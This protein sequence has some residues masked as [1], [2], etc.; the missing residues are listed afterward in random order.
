MSISVV[1]RF[2]VFFPLRFSL[3][4]KLIVKITSVQVI[5]MKDPVY[6]SNVSDF[7]VCSY[8]W[9]CGPSN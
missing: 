7:S 4:L 5:N 3:S 9:S 6:S 2:L 8:T 1:L